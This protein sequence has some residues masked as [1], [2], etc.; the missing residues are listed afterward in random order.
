MEIYADIIVDISLEKLDKTFQYAIPKNLR[1]KAVIGA[2]VII[3]FGNGNR[4]IS[5][6][7]IGLSNIPKIDKNRIKYI[8][9]IPDGTIVIKSHLISLAYWIKEN[10]GGTLNEALKTVIP[11]KKK[12]KAKEKR[13]VSLLIDNEEVKEFIEK[14]KKNKKYISRV[15][16]LELLVKQNVIDYD[17]LI[18][19]YNVGKSVIDTCVK[20]G[21]ITID[22]Q[23]IYRNPIKIIDKDISK[24]ILNKEQRKIT[25]DFINEYERGLRGTYLLFGITGSGKTEVYMEMIEF[26]ISKNKQ[27]IMLIPEISLTY[28]TVL[29]FYKRFGDKI[30]ILNSKM[31]IGE[32]YDQYLRAENGEIDIII[33]PR[34]ALFVPF[35]KLGL[36]IIDEE[37]ENSYK[38]DNVPKYHAREVAIQR[39]KMLNAS[40]VL[41]SATPSIE[42]YKNALLGKYKLYELT[43]R[44][45]NGT[46]PNIDIVDLRKELRSGN[47]SIFSRKLMKLINDRLNKKEQIILF[48]NKRGYVGF[49]SC[50]D[51]GY[52]V[53]CPHCDIS[54]TQHTYYL[55]NDKYSKLVCHYCGYEQKVPKICPKC[56][57]KYIAGFNI[58]TQKVEEV[59][60][61]LF[62]KA[63]VLRM[64]TDTTRSKDGHEHILSTFA[65][66]NADILIGTQMIVKG[67]DFPK[68]TLVGI[69]AADLSL[70]A[71]D[72]H[73][74]ERTFQ[75]LLQASGRA[76][77]GNLKGDVI[78][79]TYNPD[80]T[81]I[82]YAKNADYKGFYSEEIVYRS[83]MQYPPESNMLVIFITSPNQNIINLNANE[84][85]NFIEKLNKDDT[86]SII[87]PT[88]A[89]ISKINDIYRMIIYLKHRDYEYLKYIKSNIENYTK[90]NEDFKKCNIQFDFNP[91]NGY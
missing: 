26:V 48:L 71:N 62:P 51:C 53:K 68:V 82:V 58:G 27:V 42:T 1:E 12:V 45:G 67:L 59:T 29:R 41:G 89:S 5:G 77:R 20:F 76:G 63:K 10:F 54:L 57:S 39:A 6:F 2:K 43:K 65:N 83:I 4:K 28:Q 47:F 32:R 31:S 49:I 85:K 22:K 66:N 61:S 60:K 75:L 86:L 21:I 90:D 40:V 44:A 19:Q 14:F 13:Y 46:L 80:E 9:D 64:D 7:I 23:V 69:I 15:K 33:G 88:S 70:Y 17:I 37:H 73:S 91:V 18:K 78:I 30:S 50:R 55:N 74:S 11:I 79:Q 16:L 52:V 81:S 34:S 87:G 3:P 8:L 24:N 35:K 38:S 84:I 72:Y 25:D 36:I 56:N